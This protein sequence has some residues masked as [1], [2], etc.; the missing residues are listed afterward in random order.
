MHLALATFDFLLATASFYHIISKKKK[1][2]CAELNMWLFDINH[3]V[4]GL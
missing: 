3:Y 1:D 4:Y 2:K